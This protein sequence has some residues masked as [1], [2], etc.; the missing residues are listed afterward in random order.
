[1][2]A[3]TV[4]PAAHLIAAQNELVL[5]WWRDWTQFL[6]LRALPPLV[7]QCAADAEFLG[8]LRDGFAGLEQLNGLGLELGGVSLAWFLIHLVLIL[9]VDG[10]EI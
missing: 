5:A 9:A 7:E 8:N 10:P 3:A 2:A 1:M 6:D 4:S